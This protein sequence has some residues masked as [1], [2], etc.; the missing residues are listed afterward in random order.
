[1]KL[2]FKNLTEIEKAELIE[3]AGDIAY[4]YEQEFGN[5][6]QCTIAAIQDVFGIIDDNI[7]KASHGL[8]A[9]IG[10]SAKGH[11]G[12]LSAAIMVISAL[13]GRERRDFAKGRNPESYALSKQ[14]ME[15]FEAK[16][17]GILCNQIQTCKMGKSYDLSNKN[18]YIEFEAAGGHKDKCP[19]VVATATRFVAE[20]IVNGEI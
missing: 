17:G 18:E 3:R 7:F 5:C 8:A 4:K 11:C 20:M 2:E 14:V 13:R 16:Y 19:E 15:K 10:L 9:G 12:A 1:M 6:P